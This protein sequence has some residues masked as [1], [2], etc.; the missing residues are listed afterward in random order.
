MIIIVTKHTPECTELH[1]IYVIDHA[2]ENKL[3][4]VV[5]TKTVAY[6]GS[7]FGGGVQKHVAKPRVC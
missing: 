6:L 5:L 1:Y 3:D 2:N 7:H 4:V